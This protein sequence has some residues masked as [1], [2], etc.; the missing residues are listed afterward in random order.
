M[1]RVWVQRAIRVGGVLATTLAIAALLASCASAIHNDP[2]NQQL[3]ANAR[4]V[5]A[6]LPPDLPASPDDMGVALSFSGGG[7]RAAAFSYGVL[8]GFEN[9]P[10]PTRSGTVSLID[11]LDFLSGVSGGST[12]AAYYG[13]HGHAGYGDFKQRFLL[14]N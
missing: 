4:Q 5:E 6:D 7:T 3:T 9:T 8:Q 13:L 11:R 1:F 12:L 14:A 10:V 2:V